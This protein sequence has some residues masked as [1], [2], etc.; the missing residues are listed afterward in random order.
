MV[1]CQHR[2][3]YGSK[4]FE[5]KDGFVRKVPESAD[6]MRTVTV[7]DSVEASN[8][9]E[10][11]QVEKSKKSV[12]RKDAVNETGTG[13]VKSKKLG[14]RKDAV[15]KD[16][17]AGKNKKKKLSDIDFESGMDF[18]QLLDSEETKSPS[19]V[20]GET[21]DEVKLQVDL[22]GPGAADYND[23]DGG[24]LS[25]RK[26][27]T[28]LQTPPVGQPT[29]NVTSQPGNNSNSMQQP[30]PITHGTSRQENDTP[31]PLRPQQNLSTST[32]TYPSW[33]N[34][35]GPQQRM[36]MRSP[37]KP[38]SS[39]SSSSLGSPIPNTPT[40]SDVPQLN[41]S[42]NNDWQFSPPYRRTS[43]RKHTNSLNP[44]TAPVPVRPSY[45][46]DHTWSAV[47]SAFHTLDDSASH[48]YAN[49]EGSYTS[50]LNSPT[51]TWQHM[52]TG[53]SQQQPAVTSEKSMH[54]TNYLRWLYHN[55]INITHIYL[56]FI[57]FKVDVI[58]L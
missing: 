26:V 14:K 50:L 52:S 49:T 4:K 25:R 12:K 27:T 51:G 17:N 41:A 13:Q 16:A 9:T 39:R 35:N 42:Y 8:E 53:S 48:S 46:A 19:K 38:F 40:R 57:T 37:S 31:L 20:D 29:D 34:S 5:V 47:T 30:L 7:L 24:F 21:N 15:K 18:V 33:P 45:S 55:A 1:K 6:T 22:T 43:P 11:V 36:S 10:T 2:A 44:M 58:H 23:Q 32:P 56:L 3:V 28:S 54:L